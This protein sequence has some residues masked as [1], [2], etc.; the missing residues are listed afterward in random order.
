[1]RVVLAYPLFTLNSKL[2]EWV[3]RP[4]FKIQVQLMMRHWV[5]RMP[6]LMVAE[7]STLVRQGMF[8]RWESGRWEQSVHRQHRCLRRAAAYM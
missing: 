8:R 3:F 6:A 1:M 2:I 7:T 4:E 5:I